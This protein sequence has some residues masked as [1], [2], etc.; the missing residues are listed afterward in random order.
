MCG[1]WAA[2]GCALATWA[3]VLE[4]WGDSKT[5]NNNKKKKKKKKNRTQRPHTRFFFRISSLRHELSPTRTLKWP[6]RKCVQITCNTSSAY[7]VQHVV[8]RATRYE[9]TAQLL[10]LADLKSHLYKLCFTGWTINRWRRGGNRS[11]RRKP[12]TTS[13]EKI[14]NCAFRCHYHYDLDYYI[15]FQDTWS[16]SSTAGTSSLA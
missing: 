6:G 2:S 8:L 12:L 9:G 10:R 7:H 5:H 11:T 16:V 14:S 4:K 1:T 3:C 15:V 13:S